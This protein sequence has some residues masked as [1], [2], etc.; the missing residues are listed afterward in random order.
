MNLYAWFNKQEHVAKHDFSY[1][2]IWYIDTIVAQEYINMFLSFFVES[3]WFM[4]N[5]K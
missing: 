5:I 4:T 1:D 2:I 3:L